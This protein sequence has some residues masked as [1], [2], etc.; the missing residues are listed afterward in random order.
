MLVGNL[1]AIFHAQVRP[2][3]MMAS[4]FA[5]LALVSYGTARVSRIHD[6]LYY[7]NPLLLNFVI[8]HGGWIVPR[9]LIVRGQER[10]IN[11]L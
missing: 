8:F 9:K 7:G 11:T 6:W 4:G 10:T 1:Y 5:L 3:W 2:F